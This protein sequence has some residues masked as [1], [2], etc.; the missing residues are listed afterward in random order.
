MTVWL[1]RSAHL[2]PKADPSSCASGVCMAA[3]YSIEGTSVRANPSFSPEWLDSR[4]ML[5]DD[6]VRFATA[7]VSVSQISEHSPRLQKPSGPY[8][9]V[10]KHVLHLEAYLTA[11]RGKVQVPCCR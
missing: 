10:W 11:T 1:L 3:R 7:G 9:V 2:K 8:L 4:N 5:S 6:T